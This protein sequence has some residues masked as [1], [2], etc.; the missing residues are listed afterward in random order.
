MQNGL[1]AG[2]STSLTTSARVDPKI[3]LGS[4]IL[5]LSQAELQQAIDKEL[6][7]NPAMDRIDE[8]DAPISDEEVLRVVAPDE[9]KRTSTDYEAR[10]SM[11]A[12]SR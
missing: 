2:T 12:D 1:R 9:L 7:E 10:R 5:Q 8:P 4:K 6:A 11:P 3:V